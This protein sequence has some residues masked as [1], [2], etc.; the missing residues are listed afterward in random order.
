MI[1]YEVWVNDKKICVA[2]VGESGV[3]NAVLTWGGKPG[4][5]PQNPNLHVGGLVN[6][7][8][9]RWTEKVNIIWKWATR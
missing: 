6:D 7:E 1:A 3:L 4:R 8:H 5:P 2:G 9:V